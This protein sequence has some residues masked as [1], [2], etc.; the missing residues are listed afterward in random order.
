MV[1]PSAEKDGVDEDDAEEDDVDQSRP[2][3]D[4]PRPTVPIREK[5]TWGNEDGAEDAM[6]VRTKGDS[7]VRGKIDG[8]LRDMVGGLCVPCRGRISSRNSVLC[9]SE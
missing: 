5:S 4:P 7:M 6:A 8:R 2:A 9:S 1:S 3:K